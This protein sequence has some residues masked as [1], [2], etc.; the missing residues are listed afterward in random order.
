MQQSGI[1]QL[2]NENL[3]PFLYRNAEFECLACLKTD[4]NNINIFNIS[5]SLRR[6]RKSYREQVQR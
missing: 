2:Q 3:I 1:S 5:K 6:V 4:K